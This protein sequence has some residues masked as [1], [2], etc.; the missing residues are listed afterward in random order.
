MVELP[1]VLT[2]AMIRQFPRSLEGGETMCYTKPNSLRTSGLPPI[3]AIDLLP[4]G[5]MTQ[6]HNTS[7]RQDDEDNTE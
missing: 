6:S 4:F 2:R 3:Q 1:L 5:E 7:N